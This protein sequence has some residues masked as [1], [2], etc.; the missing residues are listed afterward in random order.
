[1]A[2][3]NRIKEAGKVP[4]PEDFSRSHSFGIHQ[5]HNQPLSQFENRKREIDS[6][7]ITVRWCGDSHPLGVK[8]SAAGFRMT[9][10][11]AIDI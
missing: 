8:R 10:P 5:L 11:S 2:T 3:Y 6:S 1:M 4:K 9:S 7:I